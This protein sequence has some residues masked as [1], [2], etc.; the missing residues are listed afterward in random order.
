MTEIIIRIGRDST[1]CDEGDLVKTNS[2]TT[3]Q[4]FTAVANHYEKHRSMYDNWPSPSKEPEEYAIIQME[5]DRLPND[6]VKLRWVCNYLK[7]EAL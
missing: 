1:V 7:E 3:G 5:L 6:L 2:F 4:L